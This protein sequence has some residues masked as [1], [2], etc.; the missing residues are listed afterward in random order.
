MK[1]SAI[2]PT[3]NRCA[4]VFRAIDSVLAQTMP[5]DEIIVVDDGS[6]D[7]T[8]EAVRNHYGPRVLLIEQKNRGV[9][10]ARTNAVNQAQGEWLAFLDS[11]D[12]W[13]PTKLERQFDALS[14]LGEDFG[15][16]FTNCSYF[17]R[18]DLRL[19]AFEEVGLPCDAKFA[20]LDNPS[21]YIVTERLGIYVQ[22]LIMRR[23][24]FDKV[25]GFD[26]ALGIS[27]DRDMM[28]RLALCT[29][30]CFVSAALVRIDRTRFVPRLTGFLARKTDRTYD[31]LE[32]KC[33]KWLALQVDPETRQMVQ[34]ELVALYY[35]WAAERIGELKF[36]PALRKIRAI[37]ETG[38]AYPTI[39]AT[40][41]SKAVK[42]LWRK[43]LAPIRNTQPSFDSPDRL[44]GA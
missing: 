15:A 27:E 2:I 28:L 43:A 24:L 7:G 41:F 25:G 14:A 37:H 33:K 12:V 29:H 38:Q 11:D 9:S 36:A 35:S 19:T 8:A 21:K 4:S 22:S 26:Q 30:F 6:S 31:W 17:G 34:D 23:S 16:C 32:Y 40:L 44:S 20:A 39:A 13:L 18:D 5:V 3:H 42:K 10:A 1:V